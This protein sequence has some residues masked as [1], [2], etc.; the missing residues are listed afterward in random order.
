MFYNF[1]LNLK[2][3]EMNLFHRRIVKMVSVNRVVKFLSIGVFASSIL[4]L[5]QNPP[6]WHENSWSSCPST[7]TGLKVVSVIPGGRLGNMVWEYLSVW[8]IALRYGFYPL[9]PQEMLVNLSKTFQDLSIPAVEDVVKRCKMQWLVQ[10]VQ[11]A[12]PS[13]PLK[14]T[15]DPILNI[16]SENVVFLLR[17]YEVSRAELRGLL[18]QVRTELR[19][20]EELELQAQS[21]LRNSRYKV[22]AKLQ[23]SM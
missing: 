20:K 11:N 19:F 8:A 3:I 16:T 21:K 15:L 9:V 7:Q 6:V 17:K 1:Y 18:P 5:L 12:T 10:K 14:N 4:L 22:L 13:R 23:V 2:K